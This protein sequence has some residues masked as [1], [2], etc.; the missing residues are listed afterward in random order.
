MHN[1]HLGQHCPITVLAVT[2]DIYIQAKWLKEHL[3]MHHTCGTIL[4]H[5]CAC[6]NGHTFK[7]KSLGGGGGGGGGGY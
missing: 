6:K 4:P 2:V 1:K 3:S 5:N 7:Q